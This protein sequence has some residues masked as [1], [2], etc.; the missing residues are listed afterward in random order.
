MSWDK[1]T[2]KQLIGK[3]SFGDVYLVVNEEG[4]QAALKIIRKEYYHN[5]IQF[6]IAF[7]ATRKMDDENCLRMY[8]WL[9]DEEISW[10]ME[11]IE[12]QPI[13][14]LRFKEKLDLDNVLKALLQV[15]NGL[16]AFHSRNIIHRDLKPQNI[17]IDLNNKIK[18][19]D[20]DF[21]KTGLTT[22]KTRYFIGTPEY[23]SPEHFISSTELDIRSDLYSLG[24]IFYELVTGRLPFSGTGAKEIGDQHRLKKFELPT[25]INPLV[26]AAVENIINGLL[27]KDPKDR[28]QHVHEVASDIYTQIKDKTGITLKEDISYLLKPKFVN[29]IKPLQM[30]HRICDELTQ[31]KGKIALII[32]ESGIG[33]TK[34]LHQF[35]YHTQLKGIEF[36]CTACKT[37][38]SS[39]NPLGLIF[40]EMISGLSEAEKLRYFGQ[41][42]WDLVRNGILSYES[43]MDQIEKPPELS[44]KNGEIRLFSAVTDFV[45]VAACRPIVIALDDLQW[46]DE[47]LYNWLVFAGRNLRDYPVLI[48]G[49]HRSE[50]IF[51]DSMV[52]RVPD[53]V[54]IEIKSLA[55]TD[56]SE[57]IRSMLGKKEPDPELDM[58]ITNLINHTRGNPLFV[59]EFLY[60][61]QKSGKIGL[62][63][64]KWLFSEDLKI[65]KLPAD[66]QKVIR[67]RI[68]ELNVSAL[69]TLQVASIIGNKFGWEMILDLIGKSESELLNDLLECREVSLIEE[70]GEEY[71]FIHDKIREV[72]E[73]D[74]KN[75]K[76]DLWRE[77]HL[78]TADYLERKFADNINEVLEDL[79]NHFYRAENIE[80]TIK[81]CEL[82]GERAQNSYQNMKALEFFDQLSEM[83]KKKLDQLKEDNPVTIE[84]RSRLF[85][86]YIQKSTIQRMIGN[87]EQAS[88]FGDAA[89][90]IAEDL[91]DKKFI[92]IALNKI[93]LLIASRGNFDEALKYYQRYL[94]ISEE[95]NFVNG[96]ATALSNIGITNARKGNIEKAME[97]F[98]K[99]LQIGKNSNDTRIVL[100]SYGN[101]GNVHRMTGEYDKAIECNDI[102]IKFYHEQGKKLPLSKSINNKGVIYFEQDD[103][104]TALDFFKKGLKIS[105]EIGFKQGIS[106]GLGNAG[107]AYSG[108]RQMDKAMDCYKRKITVDEELGNIPGIAFVSGNIGN[109]YLFKGECQQAL[110][111]Y[112]RKL[113]LCTKIKNKFETARVLG[114]LGKTY[115]ILGDLNKAFE[116]LE[117]SLELAEGIGARNVINEASI[118]LGLLFYLQGKFGDAEKY[119]RNALEISR[120]LKAK[121]HIFNSIMGLVRAL[122]KSGNFQEADKLNKESLQEAGNY[123]NEQWLS[124]SERIGSLISFKREPDL[125]HKVKAL[126]S[127]EGKLAETGDEGK[128]AELYYV[129]AQMNSELKRRKAA[130]SYKMK[131]IK[132][133]RKM[134]DDE[135]NYFYLLQLHDLDNLN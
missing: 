131:A 19:T 71:A 18:I 108:L 63:D 45:R 46:A 79:A 20:F 5:R 102:A 135:R 94:T 14:S 123:H 96:I 85:N 36:Y 51:E 107:N 24:V 127:L 40:N 120:I 27:E 98:Q 101:I 55:E 25:K 35:Y 3:G 80:K 1:F 62:S 22:E 130:V 53:L 73:E 49:L 70:I 34:L 6:R 47:S 48:I 2:R 87:W 122:I 26:P 44:G 116:N 38:E 16:M 68:A 9:F 32:G 60:Y 52:L 124:Y 54:K 42:G 115:I 92:G 33:K 76:P 100:E 82:A 126:N 4:E 106:I 21:I 65:D 112:N 56:T 23:A 95:I 133:Y 84:L 58:F 109:I 43:W 67:E 119:F 75:K 90:E 37:V 12:G 81:Y 132:F 104:K 117:E 50:Q 69:H 88:T 78:R 86:T 57:M 13:S 28:Y 72:L 97:C 11:Y 105:E 61:L 114:S 129:L 91:G 59:R 29:R 17:L 99:H 89:L 77:L 121:D 64:N 7:E 39:F 125:E 103:F 134:Y 83:I 41:F 10:L 93:G 74:L 15:C 113:I 118:D 31:G 66:I 111:W 30:L 8:K 110:D 128:L